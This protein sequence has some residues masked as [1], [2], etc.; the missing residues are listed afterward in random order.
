MYRHPNGRIIDIS[1]YGLINLEKD[2]VILNEDLTEKYIFDAR[3]FLNKI[4]VNA[5]KYFNIGSA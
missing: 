4:N 3:G 5:K 1:F 2:K